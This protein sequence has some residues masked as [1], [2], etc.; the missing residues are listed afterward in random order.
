MSEQSAAAA[1]CPRHEDQP[2]I[3]NCIKCG[4]PICR[5]CRSEFGYFCSAEC[6]EQSR[7]EIDRTA[8][9]ERAETM[10]SAGR[11]FVLVKR[12][13]L[14]V[15][16]VILVGIG[17]GVWKTW[18]RPAGKLAWRVDLN[19]PLSRIQWLDHV[20]GGVLR[21]GGRLAQVAP[22]AT[23]LQFGDERP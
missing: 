2:T 10:A 16:A 3:G 4:K 23:G 5:E 11:L 14:L 12:I 22:G 6:R 18:M 7:G 20:C 17:W 15:L 1:N 8:Q 19:C 9:A 21:C 13:L